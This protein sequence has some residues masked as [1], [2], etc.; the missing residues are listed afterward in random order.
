MVQAE[1]GEYRLSQEKGIFLC[2][3]LQVINHL[4]RQLCANLRTEQS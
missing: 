3:V 4:A 2:N 1:G